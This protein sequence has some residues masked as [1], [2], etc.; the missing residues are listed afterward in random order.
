MDW[1]LLV[2]KL[3]DNICILLYVFFF[4]AVSIIVG[5]L[6]N[7]PIFGSLQNSLLLI[8]GEIA[9]GGSVSVGSDNSNSRCYLLCQ[10]Q[11][12]M[13]LGWFW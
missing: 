9:G 10:H 4:I 12:F 3:I 5:V 11:C 8:V 1:R 6:K 7:F 2:E 13:T